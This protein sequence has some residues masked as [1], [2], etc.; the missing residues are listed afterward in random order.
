MSQS[1]NP[2]KNS[3]LGSPWL[4]ELC[5]VEIPISD[6]PVSLDFYREVFGWV[7]APIEIY[8]YIVLQTLGDVPYGISLIPQSAAIKK[9]AQITLYFSAPNEEAIAAITEKTKAWGGKVQG[10]LRQ[11]PGYGCIQFIQDP[12]DN[13]FGLFLPALK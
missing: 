8:N 13:R 2:P 12:S 1:Q 5:Q 10:S 11:V 3:G 7:P 6:I 9:G 4:P